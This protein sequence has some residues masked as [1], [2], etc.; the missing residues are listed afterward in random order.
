MNIKMVFISKYRNE[1]VMVGEQTPGIL[2]LREEYRYGRGV[3][4]ESSSPAWAT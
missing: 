2:A 1:S 3:N 4:I